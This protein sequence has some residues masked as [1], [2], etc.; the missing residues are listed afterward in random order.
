M[1]VLYRARAPGLCGV[2]R[3]GRRR[4]GRSAFA[5]HPAAGADGLARAA[6]AAVGATATALRL[7][8]A[9]PPSSLTV[10]GGVGGGQRS[11]ERRRR[12]PRRRAPRR[13]GAAHHEQTVSGR[14]GAAGGTS[15]A[16]AA[17]FP[18]VSRRTSR[19]GFGTVVALGAAG[20]LPLDGG[21]HPSS[22]PQTMYHD[23]GAHA[24]HPRPADVDALVVQPSPLL[25]LHLVVRPNVLELH[26][27]PDRRVVGARRRPSGARTSCGGPLAGAAAAFGVTATATPPPPPP[28]Q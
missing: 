6:S 15:F 9:S 24:R 3:V 7:R 21:S 18:W 8:L 16:K 12:P 28:F 14:R 26:R 19:G 1:V 10:G 20:S 25:P 4:W 2:G 11:M 23:T 5:W 17:Y 27:Q 13:R 22:T